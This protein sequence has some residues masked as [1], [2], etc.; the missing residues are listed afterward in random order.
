MQQQSSPPLDADSKFA[1]PPSMVTGI[2]PA[3]F[4]AKSSATDLGTAGLTARNI[5]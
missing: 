1:A 5:R 4:V 3:N 2:Q